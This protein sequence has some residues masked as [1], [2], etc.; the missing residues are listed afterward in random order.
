MMAPRTL[1]TIDNQ[2]GRFTAPSNPDCSS[3][4]AASASA[5]CCF[6]LAICEG[7]LALLPS[8]TTF[9][10]FCCA[11]VN[12]SALLEFQMAPAG[13]MGSKKDSPTRPTPPNNRIC[14]NTERDT[15]PL[16]RQSSGRE[17]PSLIQIL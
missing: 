16:P 1:E 5:S 17:C 8:A 3:L 11:W 7:D 9:C 6:H 14:T 2:K 12:S 4:T 15:S 10:R 13:S